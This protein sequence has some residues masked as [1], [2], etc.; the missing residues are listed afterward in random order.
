MYFREE[1]LIKGIDKEELPIY[2]KIISDKLSS[3]QYAHCKFVKQLSKRVEFAEDQIPENWKPF[4]NSEIVKLSQFLQTDLEDRD[5]KSLEERAEEKRKKIQR[6][7]SS[8]TWEEI[9]SLLLFIE[10]FYKQQTDSSRWSI[11]SGISEVFIAIAIKSK[12]EAEKALR[13]FF[14]GELSFP[15]QTRIVYFILNENIL[16]GNELFEIIDDYHFPK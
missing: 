1:K 13:L 2:E 15:L 9:K 3:D 16:S 11:D 5:G 10:A 7:I 6:E 4:I 8:K 12:I 14:S